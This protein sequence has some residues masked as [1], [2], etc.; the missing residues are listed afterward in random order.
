MCWKWYNFQQ[1]YGN[2]SGNALGR[3]GN[4]LKIAITRSLK[5]GD[6][7]KSQN[8]QPKWM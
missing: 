3:D 4:P 8:L 2:A 1:K 7:A 5:A 6:I